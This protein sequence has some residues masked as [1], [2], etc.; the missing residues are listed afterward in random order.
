MFCPKCK[1]DNVKVESVQENIGTTSITRT[2]YKSTVKIKKDHG[3]FWWL[4]IGWWWWI[5][6]LPFVILLW[7]FNALR[8]VLNRGRVMKSRGTTESVNH[9]VYKTICTCQN[10]GRT[11]EVK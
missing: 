2:S 6:K 8:R 10:C 9:I 7:P 3:F 5:F 4:L 11:W 1:S